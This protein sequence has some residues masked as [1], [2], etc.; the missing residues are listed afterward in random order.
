MTDCPT[1]PVARREPKRSEQ[2]GRVREDNYAW[3]KDDNWQQVMR[4]PGVL[5]A[6]IRDHLNAENAYAKA[7]MAPTT[8][9][10]ETIYRE[11]RGRVKEDDS[12]VPSADGA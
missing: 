12:S 1:P 9:L 2:L 6:D 11:L 7:M 4:D 3:M 10:Q 5:R 8:A